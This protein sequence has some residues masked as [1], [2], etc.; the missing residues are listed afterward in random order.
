MKNLIIELHTLMP[1]AI[2]AANAGQFGEI[3]NVNIGGV[4]RVVMSSQSLKYAIRQAIAK[5]NLR[6]NYYLG[7][8]AEKC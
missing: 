4:S 1:Y 3:K 7:E 6:T 8:I 2:N 5:N